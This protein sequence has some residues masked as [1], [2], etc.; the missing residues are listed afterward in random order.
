[1]HFVTFVGT[2]AFVGLDVPPGP[3]SADLLISS[4]FIPEF[5]ARWSLRIRPQDVDRE[6]LRRIVRGK[7]S[8]LNKLANLFQLHGIEFVADDKAVESLVEQALRDGDGARALHETLW[9]R[10]NGLIAE[11]PQMLHAGIRRDG[12]DPVTT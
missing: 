9:A 4:G 8:A 2:G 3:V 7:R 10:L 12:V 5:I 11:I 1:S 6:M